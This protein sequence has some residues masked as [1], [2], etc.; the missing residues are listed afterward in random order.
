MT[1]AKVNFDT[2][3]SVLKTDPTAAISFA[4]HRAIPGNL[5]LPPDAVGDGKVY[6][7]VLLNLSGST[8]IDEFLKNV[9]LS[10]T[11]ELLGFRES[12][13]PSTAQLLT[14]KARPLDG[15]A[16]T[17]PFL[18]N[19]SVASIYELLLPATE[20]L[21]KFYV[22]SKRFDTVQ[23]GFSTKREVNAVLLD[24]TA[25]GNGNSG[26]EFGTDLSHDERMAVIEYI[27]TLK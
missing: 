1:F 16:F 5:L 14:Y 3:L 12:R 2:P 27:K 4:T 9:D 21:K 8:I 15:I 13:R 7:A 20:R 11:L 6:V 25:L 23:L 19:G 24:T 22:G 17:A 18:H 10:R 26:H